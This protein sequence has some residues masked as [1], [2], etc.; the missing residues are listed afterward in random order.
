MYQELQM[1]HYQNHCNIITEMTI[2]KIMKSYWCLCLGE[3]LGHLTIIWKILLKISPQNDRMIVSWLNITCGLHHKF[4]CNG[5]VPWLSV[6]GV[7]DPCCYSSELFPWS[8]ALTKYCQV[9]QTVTALNCFHMG[10][11][12]MTV[13][14]TG[15]HAWQFLFHCATL[16]Y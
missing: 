2:S 11:L 15:I 10:W 1:T 6:T 8:E 12:S 13:T 16:C 5:C 14:R 3:N 4:N 9:V 7:K